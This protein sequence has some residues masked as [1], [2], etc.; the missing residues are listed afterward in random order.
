MDVK[1]GYVKLEY[2]DMINGFSYHKLIYDLEDNPIDIIFIEINNVLKMH[3]GLEKEDIIG[4]SITRIIIDSDIS[5]IEKYNE[6]ALTGKG[7]KFTGYMKCF[8]EEQG[9]ALQSQKNL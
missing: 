7:N 6:V 9:W 1:M 4:K 5:W 2:N 8:L 3:L